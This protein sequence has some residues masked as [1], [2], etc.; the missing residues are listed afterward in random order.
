MKEPLKIEIS[1]LEEKHNKQTILQVQTEV[2]GKL[3][4]HVDLE[5]NYS[6][7]FSTGENYPENALLEEVASTS[8]NWQMD[9]VIGEKFLGAASTKLLHTVNQ[10]LNGQE[11]M[12][13]KNPSRN[14][15]QTY[16][17]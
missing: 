6:F 8:K 17:S 3:L 16:S 2:V 1:S 13:D 14:I 10:D 9:L 11:A 5:S 12:P 15:F 7:G 4:K